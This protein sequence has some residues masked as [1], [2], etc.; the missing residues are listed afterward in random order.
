[1]FDINSMTVAQL[2]EIM[3]LIGPMLGIGKTERVRLPFKVGD[4]VLIRTV[5]HYDLG[6]IANITDGFVT[7]KNGGWVADTGRFGEALENGTVLEFEKAPAPFHVAIGSIV[8][9]HPWSKELPSATK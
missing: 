1:M 4:R 7:L 6:E 3:D 9:I 2:K 5:T 8:D